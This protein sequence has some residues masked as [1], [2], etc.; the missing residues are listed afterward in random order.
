M[1]KSIRN[2]LLGGIFIGG[3]FSACPPFEKLNT[4]P[5]RLNEANPG[6]FLD[7]I[8]YNVSSFSW[9]RFNNYTYELMGN[10]ISYRNTND[11]GWWYVSDSEGDGSWSTYYQWLANAKAMEKE[12][13]K[14]GEVN[15]QAVSKVLQSYMFDVLVSAFGD[16]PM[17]EAC[18]GDEQ[19][20]YPVFD[21]Q[22][23][24]YKNILQELETAN[25]L[26]DVS[27]SLKYNTSGDMLYKTV[28]GEGILKWKK[29]C[30]SLRLRV[31]LKMLNV[32]EYD[33]RS[34]IQKMI[35][36]PEMYPVF[37]SNS[38]A[39]LVEISGVYPQEAPLNRANDFT[40]YRACSE[41]LVNTLKSWNDP[42]LPLFVSKQK[43]DYIGWPA[44]FAIQPAGKASTPNKAL[45]VAPMKLPLMSYAELE[46]IKAELAQKGIVTLDERIAYEN[47]V[48]ASIEQW[49]GEIPEGYFNNPVAGYDGTLERIMLQKYFALYFCDYQQWF[50]YNRT[51]L[52]AIPKGDGIP[53]DQEIPRRFKYPSVLQRTNMK[54]YQ[55][56]K[57]S[58]GGDDLTIKL[59]WQQ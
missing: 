32:A 30:N 10:I 3:L 15:Y 7:P 38:D 39:A 57:E 59:I 25:I 26:F 13:E 9:K 31:L 58:M 29:F 28:D 34:E 55:A 33:A 27:G 54:N 4:D 21:K 40:S 44:G 19:L 14:L 49:G 53:K 11:I 1:K 8:L 22:L 35:N 17:E 36:T 41:F 18:R 20:Y 5:T 12:A 23:A 51:G 37:E 45:A 46:L 48:R 56:A 24:I 2:I 52:P 50:E 6:S 43:D 16:V 47:G 42:R